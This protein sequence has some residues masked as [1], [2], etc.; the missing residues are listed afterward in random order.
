MMTEAI[1]NKPQQQLSIVE[2][3]ARS[4]GLLCTTADVNSEAVTEVMALMPD[5]L[6]GLWAATKLRERDKEAILMEQEIE[7]H[8]AAARKVGGLIDKLGNKLTEQGHDRNS[9]VFRFY[10]R[11]A[12]AHTACTVASRESEV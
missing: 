7:S 9:E 2:R 6:N 3:L 10:W 12:H 5:V 1:P 8:R 4:I 11:L